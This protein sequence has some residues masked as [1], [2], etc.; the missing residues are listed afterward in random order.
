MKLFRHG[1]HLHAALALLPLSISAAFAQSGGPLAAEGTNLW[2]VELAGA[3]QA[4]GN[5]RSAIAAEKEKFRKAASAAGARFTE[6]RSFDVLFNGFSVEAGPLDRAKLARVPGVKAIY[7]VEVIAAPS[8][9][10]EAGG[11]APDLATAITMTGANL[12]QQ[13]LGLTGA[14]VKVAVMDTGID[15][16]HLDFGG[17]GV[18]GTTSFPTSRIT[19]GHDFV[20]DAFNADPASPAY[21]PTP[22]PD[23]NPDDCGGHGSHVA[24]IV[25]ANGTLKGVAPGVTFGAYRVFGCA[26][27]TT[28]DIMISAMERALA[29]GMHVLNMSIGAAFQWPQYPTAQAADRLVNKGMVVVTSAGNS[30][31]SGLYSVSAPGAAKNVIATASFDNLSIT[32]NKFTVS[33]DGLGIGY[34]TMTGSVVSPKSG[35]APMSRTGTPTTADDACVALPAGSL[36]GTVALIRRG[37]C[38]FAVKAVNAQAA[39]AVGVVIYNN[40]PGRPNGTI[41]GS[42]ATIPVVQISDTEGAT[43]DGRLAGGPVTMTWTADVVAFPNPTANTISS[44]SSYGLA[45]DLTLK[46]NI[47]APGG[48]IWSTIPL[49]QGGFGINS[50]TSMASPHVA[51]AAALVLQARPKTSPQ[52]MRVLLQNTAT[53]KAWWGN[54]ALGFLDNVHRQ[55][56]GMLDVKAAVESATS[57]TPSELALGEGAGGAVIARQL[58]LKNGGS[59][60]VTYDLSHAPAVATGAS[61]FTPTFSIAAAG[62]AFSVPSV[63]IPAG[64]SATVDVSITVPAGLADRGQ[65]GG[66]VVATP[67]GGGTAHRV[68]YVGF[69][70]DYQAIQVLTATANGFPWLAKT[71]NGATFSNNAA[72]VP[73]T[74]NGLDIPFFALHLD[75]QARTVRLEA[76]DAV[77]GKSWHRVSEDEFVGRN[78][79]A[80][81]FFTFAWDGTTMAG[82]KSYTVPNGTYTVKVS[83]LKPLGDAGNAAHWETWT[84]PTVTIARP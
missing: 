65:Y 22:A 52:A 40:A 35:S 28:A 13:Q 30:G 9:E 20:G 26:G 77:T 45:P 37:T 51:G 54:P 75:H 5:S 66:Y 15:I 48:S 42:G 17:S 11:G 38:G 49:E 33:P 18:G 57:F 79:T 7:P 44:F 4:D 74:M 12:V 70:G 53:P 63:S 68:P 64:G 56:A 27:S 3:P 83:V 61:T 39:G 67:Q 50:G 24:G 21:N 58:T 23:A 78:S 84:S 41:A 72:G 62:V 55:G 6:R 34:S 69:K 32:L 82:N 25:G 14:G 19:H 76:V 60:A 16:D 81:G 31:A 59:S 29:D 73:Y 10:R 46:P 80:A 2:F 43:I 71:T 47:G 1:R 36:T 8:F